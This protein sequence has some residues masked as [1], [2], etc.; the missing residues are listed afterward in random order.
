VA[1]GVSLVAVRVFGSCGSSA[2]WSTII[3]GVDWVTANAVHP[4]VANMSLGGWASGALD[5][6]VRNSIAS[7]V[8]YAVAAGNSDIDACSQSPAR[9]PEALT[10]GATDETDTRAYFSNWGPCVDVFAPGYNILSA[11]YTSNTAAAYMSGTSM[12]SPHVA[13]VAALWLGAHPTDPPDVV[14][15]EVDRDASANRLIDVPHGTA[16]LLAYSP[17]ATEAGTHI[18]LSA[19]LLEFRKVI[20]APDFAPPFQAPATRSAG[21]LTLSARPVARAGPARTGPANPQTLT[22]TNAGNATVNWTA[23]DNQRWASV[24]PTSGSLGP[25]ASV[26][27]TVSVNPSGLPVGTYDALVRVTIPGALN[28]P[29]YTTARLYVLPGT[30]LSNGVPVTG[31]WGDGRDSLRFYRIVVEPGT[32]QL[33]VQIAGGTGDADLYVKYGTPPY[34]LDDYVCRSWLTGNNELCTIPNPTPGD[35][36]IMLDS[37]IGYA[38]VT[39]TANLTAGPPPA[40]PSNLTSTRVNSN[41]IDLSWTDNSTDEGRFGVQWR[42]KPSGGAYGPWTAITPSLPPN[43]TTYQHTGLTSGDTH[44][45]YRVR[46]CNF[47]GCSS[48]VTGTAVQLP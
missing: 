45:Q 10:V 2:P 43:T 20:G 33:Q 28:S 14:A 11:Y 23:D 36:W 9:V 15:G 29:A 18:A 40:A 16:N 34:A 25:G 13:G 1:K 27:L 5:A 35:W 22:V 48:W 26:D 30:T 8:T 24:S 32:A 7:G 4:A 41:E 12:A 17:L 39:L 42:F 46:A 21:A 44:Y 31:I 19:S 47:G 38:G 37:Y 3:A 6:A